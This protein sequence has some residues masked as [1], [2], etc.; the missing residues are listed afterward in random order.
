M[1]GLVLSANSEKAAPVLRT[2]VIQKTRGMTGM[3]APERMLLDDE[4]F[5]ELVEDDDEGGEEEEE[6]AAVSCLC[7][8]DL[9]AMLVF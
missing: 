5:C 2:W 9:A 6:G 4:E 1:S 7:N 8:E 3:W